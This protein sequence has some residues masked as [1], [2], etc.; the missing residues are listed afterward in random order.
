MANEPRVA[1][2][3]HLEGGVLTDALSVTLEDPSG[4]WGIREVL[5][6]NIAV[7]SGAPTVRVDVGM[8]EYN[9]DALNS[10]I[11]YEIFWKVINTAGNIEYILGIIPVLEIASDGSGGTIVPPEVLADPTRYEAIDCDGDGYADG[12]DG[13]RYDLDGD[14]YFESYDFDGDLAIDQIDVGTVQAGH[15][16]GHSGG[17]S[18]GGFGHHTGNS[19]FDGHGDTYDSQGRRIS[20]GHGVTPELDGIPDVPSPRGE[21]AGDGIWGSTLGYDGTSGYVPATGGERTN[22]AD[23]EGVKETDGFWDGISFEKLCTIPIGPR[24]Q[25]LKDKA[26]ALTRVM[27]KDTDPSCAAF[28]VDEIDLLLEGSLWAFNA[29]PTFT[30]FLWDNLQERWLDIIVKGAVIWGLYSQGLIE[31]GREFTITDNGISFT[32]PP[33]SDKLHAYASALL[34]HYEKELMDIK[35]NFRPIPAAVGIFS[36]L[37]V[38][39]SLRRLRHLREKRIF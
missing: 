11:E 31:A 1:F 25:C 37:D 26:H 15:P 16:H 21:P 10:Q 14:G 35:Q 36:V 30:A 32:P 29:K 24:G 20:H 19:A 12:S 6:G 4:A 33:V 7:P 28:S 17:G 38:S 18:H 3:E 27:L 34:A 2:L 13:Y 5:T 23:C 22:R 39:P 9:V 8:Y